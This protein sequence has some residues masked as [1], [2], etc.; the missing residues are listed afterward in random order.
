MLGLP[1]R[2]L[3]RLMIALDGGDRPPVRGRVREVIGAH[4]P[5]GQARIRELRLLEREL[6]QVLRRI[7]TAAPNGPAERR[8][9]LEPLRNAAATIHRARR[10]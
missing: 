5:T 10:R 4:L 1:L 2:D 9:C 8:R 6:E 7:D 3:K